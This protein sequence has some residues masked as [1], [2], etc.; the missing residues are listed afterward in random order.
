MNLVDKGLK[1]PNGLFAPHYVVSNTF[2][3]KEKEKKKG[4]WPLPLSF[5]TPP[6]NIDNVN[7]ASIPSQAR[8]WAFPPLGSLR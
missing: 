5:Q 2:G 7:R 4:L 6:T 8:P 3:E 1:F